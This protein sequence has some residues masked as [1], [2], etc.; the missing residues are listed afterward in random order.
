LISEVGTSL[1]LFSI[2]GALL[3]IIGPIPMKIGLANNQRC[4]KKTD[5]YGSS[6]FE[7]IHA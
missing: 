3:S 5:D 4:H 1:A 6:N 2:G 7:Q